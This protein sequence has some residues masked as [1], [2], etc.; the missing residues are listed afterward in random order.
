M[1]ADV[2][3][4]EHAEIKELLETLEKYGLTKEKNDVS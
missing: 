4:S 3:L 2:R 1:T